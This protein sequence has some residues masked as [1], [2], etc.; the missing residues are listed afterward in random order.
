MRRKTHAESIA[1]A[2]SEGL[3]GLAVF[4]CP[5]GRLRGSKRLLRGVI[6]KL[7]NF[8]PS[9]STNPE[10]MSDAFEKLQTMA[11]GEGRWNARARRDSRIAGVAYLRSTGLQLSSKECPLHGDACP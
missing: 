11:R 7:A 6:S 3:N 5:S 2:I 4:V 9:R 10:Q 8:P 1:A